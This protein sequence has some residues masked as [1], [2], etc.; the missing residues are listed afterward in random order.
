MGQR[1]ELIFGFHR[2]I[3]SESS[4][5]IAS[6]AGFIT[7]Y[8]PGHHPQGFYVGKSEVKPGICLA[9]QLTEDA[10]GFDA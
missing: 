9:N 10:N 2:P 8:P 1:A 7:P 3:S 5:C 6:A 4:A